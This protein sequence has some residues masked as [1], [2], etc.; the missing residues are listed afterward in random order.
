LA[1]SGVVGATGLVAFLVG[2][3]LSARRARNVLGRNSG[4][5]WMLALTVIVGMVQNNL[6]DSEYLMALWYLSSILIVRAALVGLGRGE[7]SDKVEEHP[8]ISHLDSIHDRQP[9]KNR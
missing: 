9:D 7:I 6:R 5:E 3:G 8:S 1:D 2:L 4:L